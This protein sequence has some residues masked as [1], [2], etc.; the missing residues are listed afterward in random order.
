MGGVEVPVRFL[1]AAARMCVYRLR[2]A[3]SSRRDGV[4]ALKIVLFAKRKFS[5]WFSF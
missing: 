1:D 5:I 4:S 3:V 2:S